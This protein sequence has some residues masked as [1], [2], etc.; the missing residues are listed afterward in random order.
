MSERKLKAQCIE[1]NISFEEL[2]QVLGMSK[3]TFYRKLSND[4]FTVKDIRKMSEYLN[5]TSDTM[6]Y[7]FFPKE[8]V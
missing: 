7:V 8:A 6:L 5:W 2:S 4:T 1:K 3:S